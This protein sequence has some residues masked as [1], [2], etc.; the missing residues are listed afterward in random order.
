MSTNGTVR[1]QLTLRSMALASLAPLLAPLMLLGCGASSEEVTTGT[2]DAGI[3]ASPAVALGGFV[4]ELVPAAG[5]TAG[6]TDVHG[7]VYDG[8]EP[9]PVIWTAVDDE[10]GCRL[11]TPR[12]PFCNPGC[13]GSA[14]CVADGVCAAYPAA[15]SLGR[16]H[17]SGVGSR[18]FEMD[19]IL[20]TYLP[21]ANVVLPMPPFAEG[22]PVSFSAAGGAWPAFTLDARGVAPLAVTGDFALAAVRPLTINWPAPAD[23]Q[24]S[25]IEVKLDISHHGGSKG[26]IECDV[27]D[28][29]QL[30]IPSRQISSL[31][32]LGAAGF[33]S[34][35][36]RRVATSTVAL[37]AGRVSLRVISGV[38]EAV[39]V[40]GVRS[41]TEDSDCTAGT[42]CQ[43]DLS[44]G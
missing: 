43:D 4:V 37:P 10:A 35:E 29:G 7:K 42:I 8:A 6:Y 24:H 2:A 33:P 19:P 41:C 16:V 18:A 15:Q 9:Q 30:A 22:A 11:L 23:P 28:S 5:S 14:L 34:I 25:R 12:V 26:K 27:P 32:A 44:C 13:G 17:V 1:S 21:A 40:P 36:V 20:G 31:L 38:Q 3:G 39:E